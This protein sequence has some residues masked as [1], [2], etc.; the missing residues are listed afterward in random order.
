MIKELKELKATTQKSYYKKAFYYI[1][2]NG[3]KYLKSYNTIVAKIDKNNQLHK[4]WNGYSQTTKNHINDFCKLFGVIFGGTKKDWQNLKNESA[5]SN[6]YK[7]EFSNGFISWNSN[8]I[9]DDYD[10]AD[11]FGDKICQERNYRVWYNIIEL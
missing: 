6:K 10:D 4:L 11:E 7:L 8:V 3:E 1:D 5:S 2:E 9:F